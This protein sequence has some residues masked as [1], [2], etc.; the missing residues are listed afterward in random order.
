MRRTAATRARGEGARRRRAG[1]A[2][3]L[4]QAH[5]SV[6]SGAASHARVQL[7][8]IVAPIARPAEAI[9]KVAVAVARAVAGA[10]FARAV[11]ALPPFMARTLAPLEQTLAVAAAAVE[12]G[13]VLAEGSAVAAVANALALAAEAVVVAVVRARGGGA[14]GAASIA[15]LA[16]CGHKAE[17]RRGGGGGEEGSG[18]RRWG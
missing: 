5:A 13:A 10:S 14:V 3:A 18:V 16:H 12:A 15:L 9:A 4:A 8:A 2:P 17:G 1:R 6:L 7:G 11:L